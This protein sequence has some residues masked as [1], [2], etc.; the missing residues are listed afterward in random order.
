[1]AIL[2]ETNSWSP[3]IYGVDYDTPVL[4]GLPEY[5]NG[6]PVGGFAN[7]AAQQL[8]NRT[9]YL[10]DRLQANELTTSGIETDLETVRINVEQ[11]IGSR[12]DAHGLAT[13]TAHGFMSASDKYKLNHISTVATSGSYNDL[14]DKPP[15]EFFVRSGDFEAR[16]GER[17]YIMQ[18]LT[19]TLGD[20]S[21][22]GWVGGDYIAMSK[23]PTAQATVQAS[24]GIQ[25]ITS[26]GADDSVIFDVDDEIIF[27][28]DGTNWR[29]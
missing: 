6:V 15:L 24:A 4:G 17:Y 25:I 26:A 14:T 19:V 13:Q 23:S 27:V 22:Y 9:V 3:N 7:V 5:S 8:A 16:V 1:M 10:L 11:H 12:G 29:V 20:P 18:N 21:F 2:T 28:F